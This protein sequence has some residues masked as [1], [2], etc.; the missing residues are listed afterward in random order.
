MLWKKVRQVD[1]FKSKKTGN[2]IIFPLTRYKTGISRMT[3][4]VFC[5]DAGTPLKEIFQQLIYTMSFSKDWDTPL[6]RVD[7]DKLTKELLKGT[8]VKSWKVLEKDFFVVSVFEKDDKSFIFHSWE[9]NYPKGFTGGEEIILSIDSCEE[10]LL[11]A[12]QDAFDK[13][14]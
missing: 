9:S 1:I 10:E 2:Y 5:L 7:S 14:R 3:K 4:P 8:G 11:Q 6:D 12:L 13:C